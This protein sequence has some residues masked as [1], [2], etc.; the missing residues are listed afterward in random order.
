MGVFSVKYTGIGD[1]KI[2]T[3]SEVKNLK[4]YISYEFVTTK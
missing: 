4:V 3:K 1:M 2:I